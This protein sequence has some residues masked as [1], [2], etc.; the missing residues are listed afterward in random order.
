MS[1][2]THIQ[3]S[4]PHQERYDRMRTRR[5][6][7]LAFFFGFTDA[8]L[9]YIL[10]S[11]FEEAIGN[12]NV[13]VFYI[14]TFGI[15]F[16]LLFFLHSWMRRFGGS[17]L[18]LFLLF[19]AIV[20][21]T[22]LL[23]LPVSLWGAMLIVVYLIVTT[24]AW[25]NLDVLLENFSEDKRSGRIRGFHLTAMNIGLLLAPFLSTTL[26]ETYGFAGVFFVSLVFY[27]LLFF[28][29]IFSLSG[30]NPRNPSRISPLEV[31]K[32]S[33]RRADIRKIYAVSFS[34]EFFYAAMIVYTP[35]RLRE[36]G[37]EW[38]SI[39]IVFT[40]MLIPFV[41]IQYPLGVLAD[42]RMGEKE[43]LMGSLLISAVSTAALAWIATASV[44]LWAGMLFMTRL[45]IASIEILR[46]SYFYKRIDGNDADLV[47]FFRT[48]RPVGNI[49]AALLLGVWLLFLPLSSI[50]LLPAFVLLIA[51]APLISLED[52]LGEREEVRRFDATRNVPGVQMPNR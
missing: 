30:S 52:N 26:L 40:V 20:A 12:A 46:D 2:E 8:F 19:F 41:L 27:S 35:L 18:F 43:F 48:A 6:G 9:V 3:T 42:K 45:G 14:L 51:L 10:S 38:E 15:I 29:A 24:L 49:T 13:S 50:F 44:A 7:W 1:E 4:V 47:A 36:L 39:G 31:I 16:I 5:L 28:C 23:F 17:A 11:Y 25:V 34:M 22:P 21:H 33:I 37:M 32:K